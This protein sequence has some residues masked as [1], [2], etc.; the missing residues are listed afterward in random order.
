MKRYIILAVLVLLLIFGLFAFFKAYN[1]EDKPIQRIFKNEKFKTYKSGDL[2]KF[3]DE[4]WYVLYNSSEKDNYVTL[5]YKGIVYLEDEELSNVDYKV[6]EASKLNSYLKGDY[7]KQLGEDKLREVHGYKARLFNEDDMKT[8][9]NTNYNEDTDSYEIT[10][11]PD[12]ICL[13]NVFYAT[14]IPTKNGDYET[15]KED[16]ISESDEE[17]YSVHLSYYNLSTTYEDQTLESIVDDETLFL[18]PVI[19]VYKESLDE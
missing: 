18:R 11:C 7:V 17:A 5:I 10:D 3:N 14:M 8:L 16:E 9:L 15:N 6:Y 1:K 13:T 12:F 19:N 2:V 4:E